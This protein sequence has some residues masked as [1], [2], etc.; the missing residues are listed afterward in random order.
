VNQTLKDTIPPGNKEDILNPKNKF[1]DLSKEYIKLHFDAI[2]VDSHNDFLYRVYKDKSDFGVMNSHSQLNKFKCKLGGLKIQFFSDWIDEDNFN[3]SYNFAKHQI[4]LLEQIEEMN[5]DDIEIAYNFININNILKAKKLCAF[6]GIEGGTAVENLESVD[7]LHSLG[8]RYIGLTW[9][10]SNKIASSSKDE[11]SGKSKKGLTDFGK[12]VVKRMNEL[13][14]MVDVSHLG[15]KSFWGVV[16]T[17]NKP[18][19]A[20]HS[21]CYSLNSHYRNLKDEQI[22][23]IA[24]SGGVI[25]ITFHTPFISDKSN[26]T[27]T[28]TFYDVYKKELDELTE[29]YIDNPEK[30]FEEK[31]KLLQGKKVEGNIS[32]NALV[33]HIDYIKNL[34]GVDYIG[35]GSDFDGGIDTPY[36]L[37]DV[38]MYPVIT[39]ILVERGYSEI[40]IRKI[41]GLNFLRV[42]KEVCG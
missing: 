32:A 6:V 42:F 3:S 7:S 26:H 24:K 10:N 27:N 25:M 31:M 36:D 15:E 22:K 17:S 39:K 9:N 21:C 11:N 2:V 29:K 14:I 40:E 20:S 12:K 19:L 13:G 18:I 35:L 28:K 30:L 4:D 41:L 1:T 37:Y 38:T 34:V 8:V 33:D 16:E 5:S 23:A